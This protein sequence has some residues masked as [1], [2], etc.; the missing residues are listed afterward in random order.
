MVDKSSLLVLKEVGFYA[1]GVGCGQSPAPDVTLLWVTCTLLLCLGHYWCRLA[2]VQ[3]CPSCLGGLA[4]TATGY[5]WMQLALTSLAEAFCC[6]L[7]AQRIWGL[8]P[9]WLAVRFD[10]TLVGIPVCGATP[11]THIPRAR[12]LLGPPEHLSPISGCGGAEKLAH[13]LCNCSVNKSY[14]NLTV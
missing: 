4:V 2:G 12:V 14:W 5:W 7:R 9:A 10:W 1:E 6:D 13:F 8:P 3:V 11:T